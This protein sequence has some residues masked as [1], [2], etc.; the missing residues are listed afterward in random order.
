MDLKEKEEIKGFILEL[1]IK[2][3]EKILMREINQED[4]KRYLKI[5]A[6]DVER[7]FTNEQRVSDPQI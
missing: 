3:A 6:K 1:S 5:F 4:R 7:E 2:I